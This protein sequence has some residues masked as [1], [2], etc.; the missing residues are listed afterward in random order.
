MI[1]FLSINKKRL[2]ESVDDGDFEWVED[3]SK[4]PLTFKL[5]Y[6]SNVLEIG[7]VIVLSGPIYDSGEKKKIY[8]VFNN[9]SFKFV[10]RTGGEEEILH[11]EWLQPVESRPEG[12]KT[13][14]TGNFYMTDGST[15]NEIDGELI[16]NN[17]IKATKQIE[18]SVD[19]DDLGWA[20]DIVNKVEDRLDSPPPIGTKVRV[21]FDDDYYSK[22]GGEFK[23]VVVGVHPYS[24][25][26]VNIMFDED[27]KIKK[28]NCFWDC[29]MED[30]EYEGNRCYW[31]AID[32]YVEM[33]LSG[34]YQKNYDEINIKE[35]IDND[36][37]EWAEDIVKT[38]INLHGK[39]WHI[40]LDRDNIKESSNLV[41]KWLYDQG[42]KLPSS[43]TIPS[44]TR[45]R[46]ISFQSIF[47]NHVE[48]GEF[49]RNGG[50]SQW[51]ID[52]DVEDSIKTAQ[53]EG[54]D[55]VIVLNWY[56]IIPSNKPINES[57][58]DLGWA[59]DVI[60]RGS[61]KW[62]DIKRHL[63]PGDVILISGTMYD[64][65][66]NPMLDLNNDKFIFKGRSVI[67]WFEERDKRPKE[68]EEVSHYNGNI[69]M[70]QETTEFDD[71]LDVQ[72]IQKEEY[73]F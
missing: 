67:Q 15:I 20:E 44:E 16:V 19:N 58:D 52:E 3:M 11:F 69:I 61:F 25:D 43:P 26:S 34:H 9:N 28:H 35:S 7:D 6:N 46:A 18:E 68:W 56:D 13:V 72:I 30:Y 21:I 14:S 53:E 31:F 37:L 65:G 60:N 55:D 41:L 1:N 10:E 73:P 48:E 70:A 51:T 2:N 49:T 23:G 62:G 71:E 36:D 33:Y 39:A 22:C 54:F 24:N 63:N 4:E 42:F 66:G 57:E 50:I 32:Q 8:T 59:E 27:E 38:P 47:K 12:W 17:I 64:E 40:N 5:V 29:G 45:Q